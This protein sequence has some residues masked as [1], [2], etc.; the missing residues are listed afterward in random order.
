MVPGINAPEHNAGK[1]IENREDQQCI[2]IFGY[3]GAQFIKSE[4]GYNKVKQDNEIHN[5]QILED[6]IERKGEKVILIGIRVCRE[7]KATSPKIV[8][9][10]EVIMIRYGVIQ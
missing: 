3:E 5:G 2:L 4:I 10:G 6:K 1:G 9:R 8:P 7:W